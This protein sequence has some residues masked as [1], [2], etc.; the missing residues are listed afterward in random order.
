MVLKKWMVLG[1][2][3]SEGAGAEEAEGE[4]GA[5][6]DFSVIPK[7]QICRVLQRSFFFRLSGCY[8]ING[9]IC[10][11]QI[12]NPVWWNTHPGITQL[13]TAAFL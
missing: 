6:E 3:I 1:E 10:V 13:I 5:E 11:Q 7:L 9:T 12:Y 8:L 4:A 2:E